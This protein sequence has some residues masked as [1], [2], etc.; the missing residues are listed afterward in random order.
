MWCWGANYWGD[1]GD[2][3]TNP[4]YNGTGPWETFG[5]AADREVIPLLNRA[6]GT[7]TGS[8]LYVSKIKI[9]WAA[10]STTNGTSAPKDYTIQY[11]LKGTTTWKTFSDPVTATRSATVTGLSSGKYYQFRVLP[12]NWAGTGTPSATSLY[13]KSK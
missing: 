3:T 12:K 6:P 13:I 8:S 10:P 9:S 1:A 11:R 7:P 4:A 2:G 5:I